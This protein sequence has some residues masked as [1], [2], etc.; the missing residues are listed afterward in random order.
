MTVITFPIPKLYWVMV[1]LVIESSKVII[2][3]ARKAPQGK[4]T[5]LMPRCYLLYCAM[6]QRQRPTR[7]GGLRARI[8][9]FPSLAAC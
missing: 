7:W 4:H 6:I 5:P 2:K 1:K 3:V 8:I 9:C